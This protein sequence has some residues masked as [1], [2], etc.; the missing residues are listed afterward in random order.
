MSVKRGTTTGLPL[1][2]ADRR[3]FDLL[4]QHLV[5]A[6]PGHDVGLAAEDAGGV[7]LNVHQLEQTELAL[8]VVEKKA[9]VTIV[10]PRRARSS[11]TCRDVQRQAASSR[12]RAAAIDLWLRLAS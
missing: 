2:H 8:F 9:N 1:K 10:L 5:Q 11:R 4:P 12:L 3:C 7:L 6:I